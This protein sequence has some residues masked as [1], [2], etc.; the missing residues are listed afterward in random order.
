MNETDIPGLP[1]EI[2]RVADKFY[3]GTTRATLLSL[4]SVEGLVPGDE[5]AVSG[6]MAR[7]LDSRAGRDKP[8]MITGLTLEGPAAGNYRMAELM[9][10]TA[11]ILP[12]ELSL[13]G[14]KV[15]DKVHDGT[16]RA[17]L[18]RTGELQGLLPGDRVLVSG[19]VA[20]FLDSRAG[21]DKPVVITGL[22]LEGPAADNY[23]IAGQIRTTASIYPDD[24]GVRP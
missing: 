17:N 12:R 9:V 18:L 20:R 1:Q 8:V 16:T 14:L 22:V 10:A 21:R 19:G 3:D 23:R 6:G 24:P 7:F 5:V 2:A 15:A 13:S 11:S 4:G